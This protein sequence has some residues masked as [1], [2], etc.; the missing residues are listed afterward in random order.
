VLAYLRRGET[1]AAL[2]AGSGIGT[3]TAR[4]YATETVGLLAA[5]S[6][7][8]RRALRAA[9][10]A[11][12]AHAVLDGTIVPIDRV[13]ADRPSYP[14]KHRRHGMNLQVIATPDGNILPVP[15]PLPGA[16]HDLTATRT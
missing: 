9:T 12:H 13:A 7:K 6:P 8:L 4:R 3:T 11:G 14:G 10:A 2:A 5:Q 16:V 1:F 15:G